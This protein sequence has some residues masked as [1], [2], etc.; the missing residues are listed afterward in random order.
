MTNR[1]KEIRK[2]RKITQKDIA[3]YAGVSR[4]TIASLE[5]GNYCNSSVLAYKIAKFF[6]TNIEDVFDLNEENKKTVIK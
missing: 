2:I 3:E 6:G 4:Q 1:I 5:K